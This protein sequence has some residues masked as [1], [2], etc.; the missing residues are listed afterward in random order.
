MAQIIDIKYQ[1][2]AQSKPLNKRF[3]DITGPSVLNG[4][5]I[6]KGTTDFTI[7]FL[8]GGYNSSVAITPSGARVEETTDLLDRVTVNPNMAV[9]GSPRVDSVFLKYVYGTTT[10]EAEYVVVEGGS[11]P[12]PNPN[13][14]THLL[15]GYVYVHPNAQPIRNGDIISVPYGFNRLEVAGQSFFH[16]TAEFDGKVVFKGEVDFLG[17]GGSGGGTG[18]PSFVEHLPIPFVASSGQTEFTLPSPYTMGTQTL[19]VYVNG[20][21]A[22]P[23]TWQEVSNTKFRFYEPFKG[24][25]KIGAF[26][27]KSI[28]LYT[29]AS[30][31]HD[32]LYY[33]KY[34]IAQRA[35]RYA[36][37]FFAGSNG[38]SISHFLGDL[39]YH[40]ISVIPV[41][42]TNN[43]GEISVEKRDMEIIVYNSGSY[44]GKFDLSYIVKAP[45]GDTTEVNSQ[46]EIYTSDSTNYDSA[47]NVYGVV[48][49]KRKNGTMA[50]KTT[51][52]TP[53]AKGQYT[54]LRQDIYNTSGTQVLETKTWVLVYDESGHVKTKSRIV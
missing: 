32:D 46:S 10:A 44:R 51:L 53:N 38:R 18:S 39:N 37:D 26:W 6:Q 43:V 13:V 24:G 7:G 52:T 23:S 17:G 40:V 49:H 36:T 27:Y 21:L 5:R 8:R 14:N 28:S 35:V 25:E 45:Y 42:K 47:G 3:V 22:P 12:P 31:N 33:R 1:E 15:L 54:R 29:P 4:F 19:F 9:S 11:V 30:H 20:E 2:K 34:E 48:D 16:G 50:M 41:E